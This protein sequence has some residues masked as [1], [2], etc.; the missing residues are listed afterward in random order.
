MA[1][2]GGRFLPAATSTPAHVSLDPR[3]NLDRSHGSAR[4]RQKRERLPQHRIET[5]TEVLVAATRAP[6]TA[7]RNMRSI[8]MSNPNNNNG[9]NN[10]AISSSNAKGK[11]R[12]NVSRLIAAEIRYLQRT[13]D[14]LLRRASFARVVRSIAQRMDFENALEI[15]WQATA[16]DCLQEAAEAFIVDFFSFAARAA[17]HAHRVTVMLADI[18]FISQFYH[19]L[20][21]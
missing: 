12:R 14:P 18:H 2:V 19:M 1:S 8:N 6:S 5:R 7:D 17:A 13:T 3:S 10:N 16:L 20:R 4:S 11:K 15:R 9:N 21:H